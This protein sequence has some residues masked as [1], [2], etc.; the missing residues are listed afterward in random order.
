[1]M[2]NVGGK[3]AAAARTTVRILHALTVLAAGA[4]GKL[5]LLLGGAR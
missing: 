2:P 4:H 3:V 5:V 1:M